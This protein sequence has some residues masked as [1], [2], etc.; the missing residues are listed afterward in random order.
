MPDIILRDIIIV[1]YHYIPDHHSFRIDSERLALI[2][3][4]IC[5]RKA[6]NRM[7]HKTLLPGKSDEVILT[8]NEHSVD[9]VCGSKQYMFPKEDVVILEVPT[10][11]AE[12]MTKMMVERMISDIEF[13]PNVR[14]VSIG[15][16]EER[17]QTAWYT[18][19][20]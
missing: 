19:E 17:G 5:L 18:K 2:S 6:P 1:D 16:D 9:V 11:T 7:R 12:E 10:T 20:I 15:L 14:S 4:Y 13:P 3:V 8:V